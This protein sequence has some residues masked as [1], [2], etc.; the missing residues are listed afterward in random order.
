MAK[1]LTPKQVYALS[2]FAILDAAMITARQ[3]LASS[4]VIQSSSPNLLL[5]SFTALEKLTRF[6]YSTL[7]LQLVDLDVNFDYLN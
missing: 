1:Q 3:L 7:S 4:P 6:K 5:V 2:R